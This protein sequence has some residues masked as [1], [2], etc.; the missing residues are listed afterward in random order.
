LT[1]AL[2]E[3]SLG[4]QLTGNEFLGAET[5]PDSRLVAAASPGGA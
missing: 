3:E 4:E 1:G 2:T 5:E